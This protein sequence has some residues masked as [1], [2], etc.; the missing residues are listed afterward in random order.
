[1]LGTVSEEFD[2]SEESDVSEEADGKAK[3]QMQYWSNANGCLIAN[4]KNTEK[5]IAKVKT[6]QGHPIC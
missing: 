5:S 4:C 2:I 3:H 1:M 6:F